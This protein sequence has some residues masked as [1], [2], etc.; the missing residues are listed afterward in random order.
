MFDLE[1]LRTFVAI[2][3]SGSFTAAAEVVGRTPSAVSMQMRRLEDVTG[4]RLLNRSARGVSLTGSGEIL[5]VYAREILDSQAAAFDALMSE[6]AARTLSIG[7]PEAYLD[8][9]LAPL[10]GELTQRF[11]DTG[12]RIETAGSRALIERFDEAA[13]DIVLVTESLLGGD[14]RGDLVHLERGV[15]AAAPDAPALTMIPMPIALTFEGSVLRR[16][17]QEMLRQVS[18]PYRIA[19]TANTERTIR[20]AVATGQ[21]IAPLPEYCLGSGVIELTPEDGFPSLP[22]MKVR[23]RARRRR[24]PPAGDWLVDQLRMQARAAAA[25]T[26]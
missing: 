21:V 6:R 7:L 4:R 15:W 1:L 3:D 14:E 19:L 17:A 25:H 26:A 22:P 11:P 16:F 24:L 10:M 12:I 20:A 5:L 2:V 8:S 13:L 23:L 18:R 9:L